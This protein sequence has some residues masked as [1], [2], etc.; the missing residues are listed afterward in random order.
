MCNGG[1][2]A[3]W[4]TYLQSD[5]A[6]LGLIPSVPKKISEGKNVDS[7]EVYQRGHL[8]ESDQW[9]ENVNQ[10]HLVLARDKLVQE[11]I[12][13]KGLELTRKFGLCCSLQQ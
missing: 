7:S 3:K 1:S 2:I 10:A 9:L 6:A 8:E 13:S 4:L 11:T 12:S 5:P